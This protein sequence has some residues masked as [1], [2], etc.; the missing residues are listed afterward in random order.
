MTAPVITMSKQKKE[1]VPVK[2]GPP[3]SVAK[4]LPTLWVGRGY[5]DFDDFEELGN[6]LSREGT[7]LRNMTYQ[8]EEAIGNYKL[9]QKHIDH[10]DAILA[11]EGRW[12]SREYFEEYKQMWAHWERREQYEKLRKPKYDH[13]GVLVNEVIKAERVALQV[14][15]MFAPYNREDDE[16]GQ[17]RAIVMIEDIRAARPSAS[18]LE[19]TCREIRHTPKFIKYPPQ[20]PEV[21]ELLEKHGQ[22]WSDRHPGNIDL[23]STKAE[24]REV[25]AKAKQ[26]LIVQ[27]EK[28]RAAKAEAE[29]EAARKEAERL[30]VVEA[31]AERRKVEETRRNAEREEQAARRA[32]EA[33]AE[34][35][36]Q[37]EEAK[38][39]AARSARRIKAAYPRARRFA[40]DYLSM[41]LNEQLREGKILYGGCL[42]S[43]EEGRVS[44]ARGIFER[45]RG[46]RAWRREWVRT[47]FG[48][49]IWA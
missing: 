8:L 42:M 17:I 19:S 34:A 28:A 40:D 18:A 15:A 38:A 46:R 13:R 25:L 36:R 23:E 48:L 21:R 1:L 30:A 24:L 31:E 9:T 27:A 26:A 49:P 22:A 47:R 4:M 10:V 6:T 39:A 45:R 3:A 43:E 2:A 7:R 35:L 33:K 5:A 14:A 37:A 29:A 12:A 44:F 32:T 11:D 20:I 16:A 41:P